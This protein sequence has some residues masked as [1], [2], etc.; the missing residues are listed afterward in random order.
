MHR[1]STPFALSTRGVVARVVGMPL[2]VAKSMENQRFSG[3]AKY[4]G[5]RY[6]HP[7]T[8]S[9]INR[10]PIE[11]DGGL[12]LYGFV[13]NDGV[14]WVDI[15]G[16]ARIIT[17]MQNGYTYYIPSD[18]C[19]H[20]PRYWKSSN[21]VGSWSK[22]KNKD[23]AESPYS[24]DDVYPT[25]GPYKDNPDSYGPNDILR[26]DDWGRGRWLHGGGRGCPNPQADRQGWYPTSGCTRLQNNDMQ[27]LVNL[28]SDHKKN[29]RKGDKK[30][31]YDRAYYPSDGLPRAYVECV[32]HYY[33]SDCVGGKGGNNQEI[34]RVIP[35]IQYDHSNTNY[36]RDRGVL[37]RRNTWLN[38]TDPRWHNR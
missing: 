15:L 19:C 31:P 10:D 34:P 29:A 11:E 12:N 21:A 28:V 14:N 27:E 2:L 7:Q 25:D 35:V 16:L 6:Y 33:S 20:K 38:Y 32:E 3:I 8:G 18:C 24:S 22:T 9:W 4:Y 37:N 13:G 17:D 1:S 26:T 5:Y 30:V 23:T 36:E